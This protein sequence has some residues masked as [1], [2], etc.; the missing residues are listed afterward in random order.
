MR[1]II[2]GIF[3]VVLFILT[4]CGTF[5]TATHSL[6]LPEEVTAD[7]QDLDF[8]K[9]GT[10]ITLTINVPPDKE[11][12]WFKV[13]D[14]E[15]T[16]NNNVYNFTISE[17]TVITIGFKDIVIEG[18][19]YTLTLP[20]GVISNQANL[21]EVLEN[22]AIKLNIN[23][24]L[25]KELD[26]LKVNDELV[27]VTNN[28]YVFTIT[29]NT[30]VTI[31]FKEK[32]EE[33][34]FY[35]LELP[36]GITSNQTN[37][38]NIKKD[39]AVILTVNIP[40]EKEIDWLK[41]NGL[42]VRVN[43]DNTYHFIITENTVVDVKFKNIDEIIED[44]YFSLVLP[45]EVTSDIPN[46]NSILNG[47]LVTLTVNIP[48]NKELSTF[49]LN[50]ITFN[51]GD[52]NTYQ[53]N[54]TEDTIVTVEFTEIIENVYYSLTLPNEVVTDV[55]NLNEI[56]ENT[57]VTLTVN[58]P[59][60]KELEW[61]KL[62]NQ[63]ITLINNEY[64]FNITKD[65]VI[66]LSLLD[67]NWIS[68]SK[69]EKEALFNLLDK[70]FYKPNTVYEISFYS[71]DSDAS[72]MFLFEYDENDVIKEMLVEIESEDETNNI[73]YYDGYIY[74][75]KLEEKEEN[76]FT[77]NMFLRLFEN[78]MLP[79]QMNLFN[80]SLINVLEKYRD[81]I[82]ESEHVSFTKKDDFK[83]ISLYLDNN[84]ILEQLSDISILELEDTIDYINDKEISLEITFDII[85]KNNQIEEIKL[86]IIQEDLIDGDIFDISY[87]YIKSKKEIIPFDNLS[88]YELSNS[89]YPI[90]SIYDD[91][92]LI[93]SDRFFGDEIF[94]INDYIYKKDKYIE[95]LYLDKTLTIPLS[96][97]HLETSEDLILYIKW[98]DYNT[99]DEMKELIDPDLYGFE[100][101]N[102]TSVFLKVD[103]Y[104]YI[105]S[106]GIFI[107][108][109]LNNKQ[110]AVRMLDDLYAYEIEDPDY[111]FDNIHEYLFNIKEE[112]FFNYNNYL[113]GKD[114][115]INKISG[116]VYFA[117][118]NFN[119]REYESYYLLDQEILLDKKEE[120]LDVIQTALGNVLED[121]I[122]YVN[123]DFNKYYD[124]DDLENDLTVEAI[125]YS[126]VR[127]NLKL[128]ELADYGFVYDIDEEETILTI[129]GYLAPFKY[130]HSSLGSVV[131]VRDQYNGSEKLYYIDE[132]TEM[133]TDEIDNDLLKYKGLKNKDGTY[134][135]LLEL[136][137]YANNYKISYLD[138]YIEYFNIDELVDYMKQNDKELIF[139][140]YGGNITLRYLANDNTFIYN[141]T[142]VIFEEDY[143]KVIQDDIFYEIPNYLLDTGELNDYIN[144]YSLSFDFILMMYKLF[145]NEIEVEKNYERYSIYDK[146]NVYYFYFY[147]EY[148]GYD[149]QYKVY[150]I[151]KEPFTLPDLDYTYK[152]I[153][154]NGITSDLIIKTNNEHIKYRYKFEGYVLDD[155][156]LNEN[157]IYN[158]WLTD[159]VTT[160]DVSYTK[161]LTPDEYMSIFKGKNMFTL[162]RESDKYQII[163]D[164]QVQIYV[165]GELTYIYDL[166]NDNKYRLHEGVLYKL[167]DKYPILDLIEVFGRLTTDDFY[168]YTDHYYYEGFGTDILIIGDDI[169]I[170]SFF[171][172]F[173]YVEYDFN[174][175]EVIDISSY[176]VEN[177]YMTLSVVKENYGP[178][179][180]DDISEQRFSIKVVWDEYTEIIYYRELGYILSLELVLEPTKTAIK[181]TYNGLESEY[182]LNY[183]SYDFGPVIIYNNLE[184]F[185]YLDYIE[186]LREIECEDDNYYFSGWSFYY[187]ENEIVTIEELRELNDRVIYLDPVIELKIRNKEELINYLSS[188]TFYDYY[189]SYYFDFKNDVF[190]IDNNIYK[191]DENG[192]IEEFYDGLYYYKVL[193]AKIKYN[194]FHEEVNGYLKDP[195]T[196]FV[197]DKDGYYLYKNN[198]QVLKI[199]VYDY[200]IYFETEV[201]GFY[202]EY[203]DSEINYEIPDDYLY[204][205]DIYLEDEVIIKLN[206]Y[207]YELYVDLYYLINNIFDNANFD[208][209]V[210][211]GFTYLNGNEFIAGGD[212]VRDDTDYLELKIILEDK[213]MPEEFFQTLLE[214]D[215]Y[216]IGDYYFKY[217]VFDNN[218]I[219]VIEGNTLMFI[220][221]LENQKNYIVD[222]I[223]KTITLI[224][225]NLY[226]DISEIIKTINEDYKEEIPGEF[227][228]D[229]KQ[230][231]G[232]KRFIY[233]GDNYV[234]IETS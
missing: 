24:P 231:K 38:E 2:W 84:A 205:V 143:I 126:T 115:R 54:I 212:Y 76:I 67:A 147:K 33:E 165:D 86:S 195:L 14:K 15:V 182:D 233:H 4:S 185:D 61:I 94:Y 157:V 50:N 226:F 138:L 74:N 216:E 105:A 42:I 228:Y 17:N 111:I 6:S 18:V 9:K 201:T 118:N 37:L 169:E 172:N 82:L 206:S 178:Y 154:R 227:I 229:G 100:N 192:Y 112:D 197:K 30:I 8:I 73:Y 103:D 3:F 68:L 109:L 71:F 220:I 145:N 40:P 47:T 170:R 20:E 60:N 23:P 135:T 28:T 132:L 130:Y 209:K 1:K 124:F 131:V 215:Y 222:D 162:K 187:Y 208:S 234:S 218:Y 106:S 166:I 52:N 129:N 26:W 183:F 198:K 148:L 29:K 70:E 139:K 175:I 128:K 155:I 158:I 224:N 146:D 102:E 16:V 34:V 65:T 89:S 98:N 56:L 190:K 7:V 80:D 117:R 151:D 113:V 87:R 75:K 123:Y 107:Y 173:Y 177:E 134:Y 114:I 127:K 211:K 69:G 230:L 5:D 99:L 63:E 58:I 186:N 45:D 207:E 51:I 101:N 184:D 55:S 191:Y 13:N 32:L 189:A 31:N 150:A 188:Y 133:P 62:N 210:F 64:K 110:Y 140:T 168:H 171:D 160:F 11:I 196:E 36:E 43:R 81:E 122:Y 204:E 223:E 193:D 219:E 12:D 88:D 35:S 96:L 93:L 203:L 199:E 66:T 79:P 179:S 194:Y 120:L 144:N 48:P 59:S 121:E 167:D 153:F 19:F 181:I 95:R 156:Y 41:V 137:E 174:E 27:E 91:E 141:N 142:I 108:D 104:I 213:V 22:T 116:E 10:R 159:D 149:Y 217:R 46:I 85:I 180:I 53:F 225:I 77:T 232:V 57:L 152:A 72:Y 92:Q 78:D 119:L 97:E 90:I 202:L 25:G 21:N 49:K 176:E 164:T 125:F 136:K 44:E 39:T 83:K 214:K 221:D 200:E 161:M 163:E